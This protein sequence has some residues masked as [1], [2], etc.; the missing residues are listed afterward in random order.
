LVIA[1]VYAVHLRW[2]LSI[3]YCTLLIII[4]LLVIFRRLFTA[5]SAADFHALSSLI[6]LVMFTGILSMFFFRYY[7]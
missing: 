2:W 7:A 4:P 1:Q 3:A 6:K 5:K